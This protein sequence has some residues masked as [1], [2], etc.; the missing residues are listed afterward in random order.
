MPQRVSVRTTLGWGSEPVDQ[1]RPS[2]PPPELKPWYYQ[3]WFLF[4]A[5]VFWPVWAV[6]VLRSPWHNGLISGAVAWAM[7][8][9]GAYEIIWYQLIQSGG[10]QRLALTVAV[11]GLILTVLTQVLWA[12]DSRRLRQV[13]QQNSRPPSSPPASSRGPRRT[14]GRRRSSRSP[15]RK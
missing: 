9:V 12:G 15:R 8:I 3:D 7:L 6:L 2:P 11:P 10:L 13:D 5:F 14:R 1:G 4:P